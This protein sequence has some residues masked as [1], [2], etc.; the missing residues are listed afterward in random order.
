MISAP[1]RAYAGEEAVHRDWGCFLPLYSLRSE[2][3]WGAGDFTDL[4]NLT[5]WVAEQGGSLVGTLPMLAAYLDEPCEPS[6]YAPAS[7][8]AW[9]EFYVDVERI[10]EFAACPQAAERIGSAA[11]KKG[12]RQSSGMRTLWT[13]AS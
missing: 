6:P 13:T 5:N 11:F 10:P 3:N 2:R 1:L 7:R 4:H 8:L 12:S 9:N